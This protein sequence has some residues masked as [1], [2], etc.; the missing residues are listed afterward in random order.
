MTADKQ[1]LLN[2]IRYA[3]RLCQRTARLYRHLHT[4]AT[5]LSILGGSAV[6]SSAA[7]G[8]PDWLRLAGAGMLAV[9]GAVS[10]AVRPAEKAATNEGDMRRYAKL[11][12]DGARM[13][14]EQLAAELQAA[15]Q[16]DAA[17]IE[18]LRDVAW[19]DTVREIGRDDVVVQ[20]SFQQRMLSAIA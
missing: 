7:E 9:F 2:E 10:L 1:T 19:N 13:T 14:A 11:R 4:C 20:L 5:F 12:T 6:V 18:L 16:T 3:E 15:R 17:E 8:M